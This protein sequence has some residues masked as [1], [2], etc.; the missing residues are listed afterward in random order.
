M[1]LA[2][3]YLALA[4]I[5]GVIASTSLTCV[6]GLGTGTD[7]WC[8]FPAVWLIGI[9]PA[10]PMALLAGLPADWLFRRFNLRQ[11]WLFGLFGLVAAVPLWYKLA[12]PFTTRW[13]ASAFFESLTYF[14]C[15][16]VA[17][18]VYWWLRVRNATQ[19]P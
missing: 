17:G 9:V 7:T 1:L 16:A 3:G 11:W 13:E 2:A 10:I 8:W 12:Q 14:G 4:A 5:A 6:V 19:A 18:L 15:G